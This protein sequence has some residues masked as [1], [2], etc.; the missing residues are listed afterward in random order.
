MDPLSL[1][2]SRAAVFTYIQYVSDNLK[3]PGSDAKLP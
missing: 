2:H 3:P 1:V